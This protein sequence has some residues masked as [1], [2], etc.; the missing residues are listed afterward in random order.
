ESESDGD[1]EFIEDGDGQN[2]ALDDNAAVDDS[3][4][5]GAE[6][7]ETDGEDADA[8]YVDGVYVGKSKVV[9]LD[10]PAD[11]AL[12][13][14]SMELN[15]DSSDEMAIAVEHD[16]SYENLIAASEP[17]SSVLPTDVD[18]I[19]ADKITMSEIGDKLDSLKDDN[20]PPLPD[21]SGLSLA[22]DEANPTDDQS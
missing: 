20:V 12:D 10:Q 21:I 19:D 17:P 9:P 1:V 7:V 3:D 8:D 5:A 16:T 4:G 14:L 13:M 6:V 22:G 11:D 2:D 18:Q 15:I